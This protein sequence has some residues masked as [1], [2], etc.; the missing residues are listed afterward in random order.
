MAI[1][2][3]ERENALVDSGLFNLP[4]NFDV[5]QYAAQWTEEGSV[6]MMKMRQPIIGAGA[7]ADGWEVWKP[8]GNKGGITKVTTSGRKVFVLMCRPR[9]IQDQVNAMYGNLSKRYINR[10]LRGE[11]VAGDIR[12]DPGMMTE[13][14][15]KAEGGGG[16]LS[17]ESIL[18][19]N[20]EPARNP[21]AAIKT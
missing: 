3:L 16:S 9:A 20:E 19:L 15:L 12:Q 4:P 17:E 10:E 18:P 8:S 14:Q 2:M 21:S 13:A 7:T 5:K 11:T 1:E 6:E